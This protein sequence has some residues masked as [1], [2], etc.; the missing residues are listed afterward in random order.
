MNKIKIPI[1]ERIAS[2]IVKE[3]PSLTGVISAQTTTFFDNG[4]PVLEV[5]KYVDETSGASYT[6][7]QAFVEVYK[8]KEDHEAHLSK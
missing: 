7:Y 5:K 3:H 1:S 4:E 6:A 8:Q 2:K